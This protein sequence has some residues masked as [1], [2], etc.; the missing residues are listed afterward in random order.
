LRRLVQGRRCSRGRRPRRTAA[1]G[2]GSHFCRGRGRHDSRSPPRMRSACATWHSSIVV[3]APDSRASSTV[4]PPTSRTVPESSTRARTDLA[5]EPSTHRPFQED[6]LPPVFRSLVVSAWSSPHSKYSAPRM[7]SCGGGGA[8]GGGG[9]GGI[10][11][12]E[13]FRIDLTL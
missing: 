3:R 1:L 5:P 8:D 11:S 13:F 10:T 12:S 7:L 2:N 6:A 9:L 4:D